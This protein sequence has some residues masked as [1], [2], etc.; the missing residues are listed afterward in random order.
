[1][2]Y[3]KLDNTLQLLKVLEENTNNN[4]QLS[5]KEILDIINND[6][7]SN[8]EI[9]MD[10]RT[11]YRAFTRLK[12]NGYPVI[13]IKGSIS[14]YYYKHSNDSTS[15]DIY[16]LSKIKCQNKRDLYIDS[17]NYDKITI[18]ILRNMSK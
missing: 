14:L 5:K 10:D 2:K 9:Q 11:F 18:E 13:K 16:L 1:M 17:L 15:F 4:I 6:N 8:E 12:E 7:F 3:K